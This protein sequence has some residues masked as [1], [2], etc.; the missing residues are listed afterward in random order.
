MTDGENSNL[1]V[2]QVRALG[3]KAQN[4]D[5]PARA[6]LEKIA[7]EE[8]GRETPRQPITRRLSAYGIKKPSTGG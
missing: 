6:E 2:E 1:L 7:L 3:K 8:Y 4:G 5:L